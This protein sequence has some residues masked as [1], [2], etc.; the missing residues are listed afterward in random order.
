[1]PGLNGLE[2]TQAIRKDDKKVKIVLLTLHE[3]SELVRN[4]FQAGVNGYLLKTDA[5]QE[6]VRA[7]R[8][9]LEQGKYVSPRIDS[10]VAK[11]VG[12]EKSL[13]GGGAKDQG[14]GRS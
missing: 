10:A 9:V 5:E 8:A 12:Q 4:A 3:S 7:L 11:A 6:L 14:A 1:M 13:N 2:A